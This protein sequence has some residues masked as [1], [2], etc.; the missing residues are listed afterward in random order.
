MKLNFLIVSSFLI[1]TGKGIRIV[2]DP[3]Y[4]NYKPENPPPDSMERP[5]IKEYADIVTM[6]HGHFNNG[7][8]HTIKGVPRLYNGGAPAEIQEVKLSSVTTHHLYG[9]GKNNIITIEAEGIRVLHM[10]DFGQSMLYEEQ[11]AKVGRVD[12]LITP[13]MDWTPVI[14]DQLKPRVVLPMKEARIDDYMRKLKGFTDLSDKT[15]EVE[16]TSGTLPSEMKVFMLKSA[17]ENRSMPQRDGGKH[18]N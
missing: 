13:W 17:L 5:A 1:T 9:H 6:T 7:F 4:Y 14:L 12:I 18:V 2:A 10:G 11:V 8:M 3:Y 15:S 16:F